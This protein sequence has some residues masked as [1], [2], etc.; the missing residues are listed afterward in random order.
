MQKTLTGDLQSATTH[1]DHLFQSNS[2]ESELLDLLDDTS[3]IYTG[4]STNDVDYLRGYIFTKFKKLPIGAIP[5]VLEE[6]EFG[7][8]PYSVAT[9]A[10]A[11]QD[12]SV[13]PKNFVSKIVRAIGR[14]RVYDD[15]VFL[16]TN[17]FDSH[18]I[19]T[20]I[21]E[22]VRLLG[23]LSAKL[24]S[25]QRAL[26][27]LD[28]QLKSKYSDVMEDIKNSQKPTNLTQDE[29]CNC[30]SLLDD[31]LE[32]PNTSG[33]P[34]WHL[35]VQDQ[36]GR[37]FR[38]GDLL[39]GKPCALAFF[40][41]RCMSPEKCS[42]TIT[43]LARLQTLVARTNLDALVNLYA[44]TYDPAFDNPSRLHNYGKDR[45]IRYAKNMRL[46]RTVGSFDPLKTWLL[47]GVNYGPVTV[48]RHRLD[49]ILSNSNGEIA[50]RYERV[51]WDEKTVCEQ[52][53]ELSD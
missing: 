29:C 48:N 34:P 6:F 52:L 16:H 32:E 4:R 9:A 15:I 35:K 49:F 33:K 7:R 46:I 18:V 42:S 5:F 12:V 19:T 28:G 20:P 37:T 2:N 30:G 50:H 17:S 40:Y 31:T 38:L 21:A 41:T 51:T 45:G 27:S 23:R 8:N 36:S 11:I 39:Q 1:V 10:Y 14:V 25:A 24:I 22:L 43:R 26:D 3:M 44:I 47:L 13:I 53:S